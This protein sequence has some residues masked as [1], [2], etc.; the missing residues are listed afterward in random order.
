MCLEESDCV[1]YN[2]HLKKYVESMLN[3][4]AFPLQS[5]IPI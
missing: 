3:I 1:V 4:Y 5:Q 2:F